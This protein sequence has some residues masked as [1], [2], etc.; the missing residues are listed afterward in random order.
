MVSN[1][2]P[3]LFDEENTDVRQQPPGCNPENDN[4][5]NTS[6]LLSEYFS[7]VGNT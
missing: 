1:E 5:Q 3:V 7:T 2:D 4:F 6:V